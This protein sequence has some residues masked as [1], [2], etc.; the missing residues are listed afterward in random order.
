MIK[1]LLFSLILA[2]QLFV[3]NPWAFAHTVLIASDPAA[4]STIKKLPE[5]IT[6]TFADPLLVLGKNAINQIQVLAPDSSLISTRVSKVTGA[7]LSNV[8]A[9]EKIE[10]GKFHVLF[11]VVAQD[12]HIVSGDFY[13]TVSNNPTTGSM[14]P[15][16]TGVFGVE[17]FA[18]GAGV[19]G[20]KSTSKLNATLLMTL[21]FPRNSICYTVK[22]SI[23][24]IL[25]IHI[26]SQNQKNLTISDE[27]FIP[28]RTE[29][30]NA[31]KPV[32]DIE[33][34]STLLGLYGNLNH[35]VMMVHT[36][37][38]PD[39]AVAGHLKFVNH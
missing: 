12:G 14:R 32:C 5:K 19:E 7:I 4:N 39:G 2:S 25:A 24:D 20:T 23:S 8:L 17:A 27:I 10:S 22:S 28:L 34:K 35:F 13:F 15:V 9:P 3:A 38:F 26:H 31:K 29:S 21:N 33:P 37:E 30:L 18:T 16:P 1:R 6:L 11:R 36:L